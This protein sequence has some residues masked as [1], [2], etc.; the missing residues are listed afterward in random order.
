M[1]NIA[2]KKMKNML[3]SMSSMIVFNPFPHRHLLTPLGNEPFENSG[4]RRNLSGNGL[5]LYL[6]TS[7]AFVD[8]VDQDQTAQNLQSDL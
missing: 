4:K 3:S 1:E 8:S 5:T 7:D 2:K 6:M